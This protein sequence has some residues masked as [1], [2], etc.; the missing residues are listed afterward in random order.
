MAEQMTPA[1][2]LR[3]F[4]FS[5]RSILLWHIP[6]AALLA[7]I[8]TLPNPP[9][10]PYD[11]YDPLRLNLH[12]GYPFA[13]GMLLLTK[14]VGAGLLTLTWLV[15]PWLTRT[16]ARWFRRRRARPAISGR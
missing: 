11:P 1:P 10:P 7:Y 13:V 14:I 4:Q 8:A 2:K 6:C 16:M 12:F 3:W 5:L 9:V 15:A